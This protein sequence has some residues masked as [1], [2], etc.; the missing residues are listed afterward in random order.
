MRD[1]RVYAS[2]SDVYIWQNNYLKNSEPQVGG[3]CE[4]HAYTGA[5]Q[6]YKHGK[7]II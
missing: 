6:R 3:G 4:H 1:P 7:I 5:R 2:S